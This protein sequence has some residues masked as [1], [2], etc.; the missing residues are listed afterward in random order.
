MEA[1]L[2]GQLTPRICLFQLPSAGMITTHDHIQHFL[3][4]GS[5]GLMHI[6]ATDR[7]MSQPKNNFTHWNDGECHWCDCNNFNDWFEGYLP[8][9]KLLLREISD[10]HLTG[11]GDVV[12]NVSGGF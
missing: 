8:G 3:N 9:R 2:P 1:G 10:S 11:L 12:P 6:L 7:S 5:G 4:E